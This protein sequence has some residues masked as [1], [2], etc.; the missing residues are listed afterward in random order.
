MKYEAPCGPTWGRSMT[1]STTRRQHHVWKHYLEGWCRGDGKLFCLRDGSLFRTSPLNIM[2]ERDFYRLMSFTKQDIV[3]FNYWL[4]E[5]CPPAMQ[6]TNRSTFSMFLKV[7]NGNHIVQRSKRVSESEK[8]YVF[9]LAVQLE[10]MLHID[11]ENRAVP[12]MRELRQERLDFLSDDVS[13]VSF[14][15]FLAH[16]H[17]RTKRIRESVGQVLAS[18]S[19]GFDFRRLRHVFCYCF[20]NNFGGSLYVDRNRLQIVFLRNQSDGFITGDQ[21][22]VN[23]AHSDNMAHDDV[24]MYYPLSPGLALMVGF[25]DSRERS[26]KVSKEVVQ[27]LNETVAFFSMQ[28]LVADSEEILRRFCRRPKIKPDVLALMR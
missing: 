4:T 26:I 9:S 3:F 25:G 17:F 20:A 28:F 18:L 6:A 27:R 2:V 7:A 8:G 12:L 15:Q 16:Q 14:F 23:L 22:I 1:E 5:V 11:I 10:E 24:V 19:P 13:T 21:P